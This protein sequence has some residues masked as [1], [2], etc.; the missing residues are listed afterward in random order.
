[1]FFDTEYLL[2]KNG[3]KGSLI[4]RPPESQSHAPSLA[5]TLERHLELD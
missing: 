2:A 4:L 1:M 3:E 5:S